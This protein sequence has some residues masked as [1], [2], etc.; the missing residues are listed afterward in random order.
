MWVRPACAAGLGVSNVCSLEDASP[1][2]ALLPALAS[3]SPPTVLACVTT[4][5]LTD[6]HPHIL[7]AVMV[8][9]APHAMRVRVWPW[10]RHRQAVH[11]PRLAVPACPGC[12]TPLHCSPRCHPRHRCAGTPNGDQRACVVLCVRACS[13]V[14]GKA[15]KG[16]AHRPSR[17]IPVHACEHACKQATHPCCHAPFHK[18]CTSRDASVRE[19]ACQVQL[20]RQA[21][22]WGGRAVS[23]CAAR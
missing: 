23:L 3:G 7:R 6:A 5:L 17:S 13:C 22:D 20:R 9:A 15:A 2:D 14:P 4:Q 19:H 18:R 8:G 16:A 10:T 1:D 12:G 11:P 21:L